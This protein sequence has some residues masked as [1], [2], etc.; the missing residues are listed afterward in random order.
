MLTMSVWPIVLLAASPLSQPAFRSQTELVALN[1]TVTDDNGSVVQGLRPQAFT[2][3]EDGKPQPII[4]FASDPVP[5]TLAVALDASSSMVGRRFEYARQAVTKLLDRLGPDDEIVVFGFNDT[6]F[7]LKQ[8]SDSTT[9]GDMPLNCVA[10][11]GDTALYDMVGVGIDALRQSHN[12]RQALVLVTD[13]KDER[14][15]DNMQMWM[16]QGRA[17]DARARVRRDEALVYAIGVDAPD[18][19][20]PLRVDAA[21]LRQLTDQSGG[22]TIIVRSDEAVLGAAE[23]IGDELRQQYVI[24]FAPAHPGDGKFHKVKVAVTGC[25]KCRVRARAGFIADKTPGR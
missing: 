13:G 7:V 1:I 22:A 21:A 3:S 12:R 4:Q 9:A 6:P 10:P 11:N 5:L 14:A 18:G 16:V 15:S 23:R 2:V 17:L 19:R 25:Q 20:N 8:W 24:G